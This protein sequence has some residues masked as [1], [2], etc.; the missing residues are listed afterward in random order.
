MGE[1]KVVDID[2]DE[3]G[4]DAN[5]DTGADAPEARL[6]V[7]EAKSA[8]STCR[9]CGEFIPGGGKR[10]GMRVYAGGRTVTVWCHPRCWLD[11]CEI[12]YADSNRGKCFAARE[13]ICKGDLRLRFSVGCHQAYWSAKEAVREVRDVH[14]QGGERPDMTKWAG[15]EA[16]EPGH[17]EQLEAW[18]SGGP[19]AS[20]RRNVAEGPKPAKRAKTAARAKPVAGDDVEITRGPAPT[21]L[22]V[23]VQRRPVAEL[24]DSD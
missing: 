19:P 16:L 11:S 3:E 10:V 21:A 13:K 7:K 23:S 22:P 1:V 14:S 6:F 24:S 4:Q 8:R 20:L 12:G 18:L 2:E 17:R 15:I 5:A 9:T